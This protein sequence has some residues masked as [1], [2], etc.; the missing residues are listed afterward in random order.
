M[1]RSVPIVTSEGAAMQALP[2]T[3]RD[4][5]HELVEAWRIERL[6][7]A[8]YRLERNRDDVSVVTLDTTSREQYTGAAAV[9]L[10]G[11]QPRWH[12][13]GLYAALHASG[14][15]LGLFTATER[16]ELMARFDTGLAA[17]RRLLTGVD[18]DQFRTF[19]RLV[20]ADVQGGQS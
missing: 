17:Y 11:I 20:A 2:V 9:A 5:A 4:L 10:R 3:D 15:D 12:Q 8:I 7:D 6:A 14:F 18:P 1:L 19:A 16:R 13:T